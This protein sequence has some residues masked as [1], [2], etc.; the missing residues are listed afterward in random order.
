LTKVEQHGSVCVQ[1]GTSRFFTNCHQNS[2]PMLEVKRNEDS[3]Y[4]TRPLILTL[5]FEATSQLFYEDLRRRYFPPERNLI[6][7][8]L[9]L[10]HQLPDDDDTLQALRQAAHANSVFLLT[11]PRPRLIGRGVAV[12]FHSQELEVLHAALSVAFSTQIIPQD[13]QRF[14]PHVVVQNK[15]DP[16]IARELL[17]QLQTISLMEPIAI[18]LTLW[19]YL[20][21]P[22]ERLHD[23]AFSDP[24]S[25]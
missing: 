15:V 3:P 16:A 14:H 21:G 9:S 5:Q 11:K 4:V 7:A 8:H 1:A 18:G 25:H 23:F 22:W 13:R 12:F 6:P 2:H 10:F 20:G 19:R 24:A 17:P